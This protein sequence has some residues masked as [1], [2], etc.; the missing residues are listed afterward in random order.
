MKAII[1]A[2]G[3]GERLGYLTSQIPKPM[4]KVKGKPI[5][6]HNIELCRKYGITDIY[7]N[8][9]HLGNVIMDYFGDGKEY[10]VTI[11]YS[12]EKILLGTAGAVRKIIKDQWNSFNKV[13]SSRSQFVGSEDFFVIYGDNYSNYN[14]DLLKLKSL[15]TDSIAIIAFHYREDVSNSG[16][17]EFGREGR[18]LSFIEKP[19]PVE[20][21]SHWV[22]AGIYYLKTTII[23][24]IPDTCSDFASDVFPYLLQNNIP[25]FGVCEDAPLLAFD[26]PEMLKKNIN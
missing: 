7:I 5:L 4:I 1:L 22:N 20:T 8:L 13:I 19:T 17:A 25:F 6:Q 9:H 18:I 21:N 2:A 10:N 12:D 15:E 3:K 23:K 14:L 11:S 24:Y 16:V 26:T